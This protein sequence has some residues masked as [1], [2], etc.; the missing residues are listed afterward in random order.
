MSASSRPPNSNA[1]DGGSS[2][3]PPLFAGQPAPSWLG[4]ASDEVQNG[5]AEVPAVAVDPSV[6]IGNLPFS[7]TEPALTELVQQ[8][9]DFWGIKQAVAA[10]RFESPLAARVLSPTRVGELVETGLCAWWTTP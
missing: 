10:A 6:F 5:L 3:L 1:Q 9:I 2:S 7:I 4:S 8:R